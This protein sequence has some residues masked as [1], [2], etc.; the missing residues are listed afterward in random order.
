MGPDEGYTQGDREVLS[1][2]FTVEVHFFC[3]LTA[4]IRCH[5]FHDHSMQFIED[6]A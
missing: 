6:V 3:N 1:M 2:V 5:T 4:E